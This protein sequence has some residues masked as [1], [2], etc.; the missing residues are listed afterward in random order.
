VV[1]AAYIQNK[2]EKTHRKGTLELIDLY[3]TVIQVHLMFRFS[4]S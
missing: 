1:D 2:N 3:A 4:I